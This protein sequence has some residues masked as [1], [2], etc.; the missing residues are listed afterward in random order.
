ME[1]VIE[2]KVELKAQPSEIVCLYTGL[3]QYD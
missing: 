2:S 1:A 3:N